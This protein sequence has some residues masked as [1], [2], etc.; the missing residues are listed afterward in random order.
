[1]HECLGFFQIKFSDISNFYLEHV[2][3]KLLFIC[4]CSVHKVTALSK[5]LLEMLF[6]LHRL[7]VRGGDGF[8]NHS[9]NLTLTWD[10]DPSRVN[11]HM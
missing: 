1:M 2:L 10:S 7:E 11:S 6:F 8:V 9:H 3:D 5:F 4:I